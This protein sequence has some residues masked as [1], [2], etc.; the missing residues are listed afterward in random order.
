LKDFTLFWRLTHREED[1]HYHC[2]LEFAVGDGE[3]VVFD[4]ADLWIF[5]H[6]TAFC[7][8]IKGKPAICLTATSGDTA[9]AK[10][11]NRILKTLGL[12]T[13]DHSIFGTP[14]P[15]ISWET[16]ELKEITAISISTWLVEYKV[17]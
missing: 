6:P 9:E 13:F 8:F 4:E 3:L 17:E 7:E 2:T 15:E 14:V 12:K 1:I 16:L 11:E 5:D 10:L